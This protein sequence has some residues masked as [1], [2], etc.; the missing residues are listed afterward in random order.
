MNRGEGS[1]VRSPASRIIGSRLLLGYLVALRSSRVTSEGGGCSP[2]HPQIGTWLQNGAHTE[3]RTP[4]RF[5]C[6]EMAPWPDPFPSV[7]GLCANVYTSQPLP[8]EQFPRAPSS[9]VPE[10]CSEYADGE[11][12]ESL[13]IVS[14]IKWHLVKRGHR[15]RRVNLIHYPRK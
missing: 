5:Q 7:L 15:E 10:P 13:D 3:A 1:L 11:A 4:G 14:K 8:R 2:S 6:P 12:N 9:I